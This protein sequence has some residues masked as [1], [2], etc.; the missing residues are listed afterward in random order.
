VLSVREVAAAIPG[1]R[2][3]GASQSAP[4]TGVTLDS[5]RAGPGDLYA[6]LPGERAHGAEFAAQARAS[7]CVAVLTDE[8]GEQRSSATGLPVIVVPD[9][10]SALGEVA[11]LVYGRPAD[12]LRLIGVTGTQGK[13]T[14]TRLI[15]GAWLRLGVP[16]GV[17][18]TIGTRVRG[19]VVKTALTTPEAPDLHRLFALMR[20]QGVE[21][22]AMEVSSHALVK[23]RVD[24]V[25]FAV[26]AF[27][28]FGRDHL[29][30][31]ADLED[32]YAAKAELFSPSRAEVAVI[33]VDDPYGARLAAEVAVPVRTVALDAA[34]ADYAV[35]DEATFQGGS[36]FRYRSPDGIVREG[37]VEMPG[38]FNVA[39]ALLAIACLAEAG[40]GPEGLGD[41]VAAAG[42]VPGRLE[43]V[44]AGQ[45]FL[46]V[47]DY[48]HKPEALV[49]VLETLHA[50]TAGRLILVFGAGGD[51]DRGKRPIMGEIAAR[52]ADV[53]VVTDDN[54]RSED[55]DAIRAAIISGMS[56]GAA[57]VEDVGDRR[58]AIRYAV[59][60]AARGDTIIVAGKGH[61]SGQEVAG[62]V[63]PFDDRTV[64]R[65]ELERR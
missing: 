65:E 29:D 24:G 1:A 64:L 35:V 56:A 43:R 7:G 6:A 27:T 33:N 41:A 20:D 10:R 40:Y 58:E 34:G 44:D 26:A 2:L 31:H 19:E 45:D 57:Q 61:E 5:R 47:V 38:R 23:G 25:V 42:G 50:S 36:R 52:I 53:A 3:V 12:A 46:A 60:I 48:A 49:A 59:S 37:R 51:R 55:P 8:A 30:F 11:A 17:I 9:P 4:V 62:V 13:T 28:N 18:G 14:T 21:A 39:N 15:D 16:A 54:P 63:H 32:Y 22:C